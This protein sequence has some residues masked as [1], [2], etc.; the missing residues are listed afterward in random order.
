LVLHFRTFAALGQSLALRPTNRPSDETTD[1]LSLSLAAK[2]VS[3]S[4][5]GSYFRAANFRTGQGREARS[6]RMN[7]SPTA[8]PPRHPEVK[9]LVRTDTRPPPLSPALFLFAPKVAPAALARLSPPAPTVFLS[10]VIIT[11]SSTR[12]DGF[13]SR[14]SQKSRSHTQS[15][16]SQHASF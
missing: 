13:G 15:L 1:S 3:V 6:K 5:A 7:I 2:S 8:T 9:E 10:V 4:T 16:D 14:C 12:R 11:L